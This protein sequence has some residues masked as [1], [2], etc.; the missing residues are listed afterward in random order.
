MPIERINGINIS[1]DVFGSG[2]PVVLITGSGA[3]A[4]LW[5]PLQ[6]PALTEAAFRVIA[7]ENRGV[8]PTDVGP[9]GFTLNDMADDVAGLIER[10]G[11]AP[12]RIVGFSLGGMIV[13]ELLLAHPDL[14]TQAVLMA[15]R[16]R[17]D[18]L[19]GALSAAESD[20]L[21]SGIVL[22]PRYAACIRALQNLS[23]RVLNDEQQIRDWLDVLEL[24]PPDPSILSAQR[25]LDNIG[26]RLE[27]YR[28]VRA[29]CMVIGFGD[30][31]M[32]PPRL[33]REVAEHIPDCIYEEVAGCG[34]YGYLEDADSVNALIT[35]FFRTAPVGPRSPAAAAR[36]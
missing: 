6:V 29:Q 24:S 13:L 17:T 33:C 30:D 11:I 36:N 18:A 2:E 35:R 31:L 20:L 19:G 12:C 32:V 26:N 25:G 4:R 23:R 15:T 5:K 27:E 28:K 1:F 34:H 10:L 8:P 22:P 21:D 7:V 14:V 9:K 3:R 16:G